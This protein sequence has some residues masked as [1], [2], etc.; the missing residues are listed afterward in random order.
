[1]SDR[2]A[3]IARV[4]DD[5][6]WWTSIRIET[7][8]TI[9]HSKEAAE[10]FSK[11]GSKPGSRRDSRYF[12]TAA[13]ERRLSTSSFLANGKVQRGEDVFKDGKATRSYFEP[14]KPSRPTSVKV[15]PAFGGET[16]MGGVDRPVPLKYAY[17]G[18]VPLDQALAK[19]RD[20]G[21][22]EA[23]SA[24]CDKFMFDDVP[25]VVGMP[26]QHHL[27]YLRQEDSL[28]VR[29]ESYNGPDPATARKIWVWE[30]EKVDVVQ[31]RPVVVKSVSTAYEPDG[32]TVRSTRRHEVK[33]IAF[34]EEV[35]AE[36]FR[37]AVA[38]GTE[39]ATVSLSA[40]PT[41]VMEN[42]SPGLGAILVL[43]G[44]ASR[45]GR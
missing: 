8:E 5:L 11:D 26:P 7:S 30:A 16:A 6:H 23:L 40:A 1:M 37:P 14:D 32:A 28:P 19:A 20:L 18:R 13:G 27:Y 39:A 45:L 2:E 12:E 10:R 34:N 17:V 38:P 9:E 31:G 41:P 42:A 4:S 43:V 3:I 33:Y 29:V 35:G 15:R 25:G 44:V 22:G 36:C 24:P 21:P